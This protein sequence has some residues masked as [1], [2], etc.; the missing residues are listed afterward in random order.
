MTIECPP[1]FSPT[2]LYLFKMFLTTLT[3]DKACMQRSH[4]YSMCTGLLKAHLQNPRL[5]HLQV[6]DHLPKKTIHP[7]EPNH[8]S[9]RSSSP[10]RKC[11][12]NSPRSRIHPLIK[13]TDTLMHQAQPIR[14]T[15]KLP[16]LPLNLRIII[17]R[18]DPHNIRH[19]P[20]IPKR[21]GSES[22]AIISPNGTLLNH[23]VRFIPVTP[24]AGESGGEE[25]RGNYP[26]PSCGPP[27]A[28]RTG[29]RMK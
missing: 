18:Q 4:T 7:R 28:L 10:A 11:D 9:Q 1:N 14:T 6:Q 3:R 22:S 12:N 5:P 16:Q 2:I 19:R 17:A 25:R 23:V 21:S 13:S 24:A 26:G 27:I 29:P 20:R 8:N 15:N